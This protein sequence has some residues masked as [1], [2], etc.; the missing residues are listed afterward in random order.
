[1]GW[2]CRNGLREWAEDRLTGRGSG[3]KFDFEFLSLL[4]HDAATQF[5]VD[6]IALLCPQGD[7]AVAPNMR[8]FP[9][10][11]HGLPEIAQCAAHGF[12]F[13]RLCGFGYCHHE[14][15]GA[16]AGRKLRETGIAHVTSLAPKVKKPL[17]LVQR[18][19]PTGLNDPV[20]AVAFWFSAISRATMR[21]IFS[22]SSAA[23]V[24]GDLVRIGVW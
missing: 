10:H 14:I 20:Q 4:H 2:C 21:A 24:F 12:D 3:R 13:D 18:L 9:L 15:G 5:Q 23:S 11:A 8:D 19:H 7:T 22:T 16:A 17:N 1:M 6:F